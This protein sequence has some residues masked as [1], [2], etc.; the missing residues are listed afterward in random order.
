MENTVFF[1]FSGQDRLK[2]A[3]SLNFH[4][5][6]FGV[7]VWYDYEQIFLGDIGDTVNIEDGLHN[8]RIFILFFSKRL[9]QSTGATLEIDEIK[10][11]IDNNQNLV[12]IP[13]FR[14]NSIPQIPPKYSW[15][16]KY[17]YGELTESTG[18]YD[19]AIDV[20]KRLLHEKLK[21]VEY[22]N[23]LELSNL[24]L[25]DFINNLIRIYMS[26][27]KN[28]IHVRITILYIMISYLLEKN[29]VT[30]KVAYFT[31]NFIFNKIKLNLQISIQ[32]LICMESILIL[33]INNII[34]NFSD[35][36]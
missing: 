19:L 30:D 8:S 11:K 34:C 20:L 6:N 28:N 9:F 17:I 16:L 14:D 21:P 12:I 2:Y 25:G 22:K 3:Q 32:E 18:T 27:D 5:K 26:I 10:K 29:G 13:V 4:L 31:S 1:C 33:L 15:L 7:D 35:D 36:M 24:N 23:L